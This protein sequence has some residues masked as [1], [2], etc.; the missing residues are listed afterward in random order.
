MSND[1]TAAIHNRKDGTIDIINWDSECGG[2][3]LHFVV[4]EMGVCRRVQWVDLEL[5]EPCIIDEP[6]AIFS[7]LKQIAD[8]ADANRQQKAFEDF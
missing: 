2:N 5:D 7:A 3:D 6:I 8:R 4:D 1:Y